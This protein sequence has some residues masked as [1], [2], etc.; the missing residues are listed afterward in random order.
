MTAKAKYPLDIK[1]A[2]VERY[3]KGESVS[4]LAKELDVSLPAIY[5]WISSA[6]KQSEKERG[7]L[8]GESLGVSLD[9]R[10]SRGVSPREARLELEIIQLKARL[11]D[12]MSK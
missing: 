12:L 7:A 4:S 6:N 11:Y 9:K 1:L 2:T 8:Q 10:A 5:L 3:R